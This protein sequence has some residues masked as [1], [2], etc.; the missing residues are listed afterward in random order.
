M[1]AKPIKFPHCRCCR[2]GKPH[3]LE[4]CVDSSEEYQQRLRDDIQE[5]REQDDEYMRDEA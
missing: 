2:D 3:T 4:E 5:Q 1:D